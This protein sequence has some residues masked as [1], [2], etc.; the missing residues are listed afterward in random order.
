MTPHSEVAPDPQKIDHFFGESVERQKNKETVR[1]KMNKQIKTKKTITCSTCG[2]TGHNKNNEKFHPDYKFTGVSVPTPVKLGGREYTHEEREKIEDGKLQPLCFGCN[3]KTNTHRQQFI[4][5]LQGGGFYTFCCD[6]TVCIQ[7]QWNSVVED[8]NN[9]YRVED[10][11]ELRPCYKCGVRGS[12]YSFDGGEELYEVDDEWYCGECKD[13]LPTDE[14]K[15]EEGEKEF[16]DA[17]L[18]DDFDTMKSLFEQK[19]NKSFNPDDLDLII[20]KGGAPEPI[21]IVKIQP[22]VEQTP[23]EKPIVKDSNYDAVIAEINAGV[24]SFDNAIR[25]NK[26]LFTVYKFKNTDGGRLAR[27]KHR[28]GCCPHQEHRLFNYTD[29]YLVGNIFGETKLRITADGQIEY[30][31]TY[32][33]GKDKQNHFATLYDCRLDD[34]DL[35]QTGVEVFGMRG[36]HLTKDGKYKY[37]GVSIANLKEACKKNGIKGF[38]GKDKHELV[39]LLMKV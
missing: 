3:I 11:A 39:K 17:C 5:E 18:N 25:I 36:G 22:C 31:R 28:G 6:N 26:S 9:C 12:R 33:K 35:T 38:S 2:K 7:L 37:E 16:I 32:F 29:P 10:K 1:T 24:C 21:P 19:K 34:S 8:G 14:E 23:I 13:T 27:V 20:I 4:D 15:Y 30:D